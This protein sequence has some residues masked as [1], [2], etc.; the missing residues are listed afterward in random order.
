[1]GTKGLSL[2]ELI[3]IISLFLIAFSFAAVNIE[4][5]RRSAILANTTGEIV[6]LLT[7]AQSKTLAGENGKAYKVRFLVDEVRLLTDDDTQ[8]VQL[9]LDS[10]LEIIPPGDDITFS[11]VTGG[12]NGGSLI[13][14]WKDL[15]EQRTIT[16]TALGQ[17][18]VN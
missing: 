1:M 18:T 14:R 15:S 9:K 2:L 11:K 4:R 7:S 5:F 17:I 8:L 3:I 13:L 10:L 16:V 6:S 12:S